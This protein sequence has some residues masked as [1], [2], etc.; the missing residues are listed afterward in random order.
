MIKAVVFDLDGTLLNT[1]GDIAKAHNV[2]LEKF[3]FPQRA[4]EDFN[5]IIG[6]GIM[7][8]IKKA[9]P[10]GTPDEILIKIHEGY[11]EYYPEHC[12]VLTC[13]YSGMPE[14][15]D[16]LKMRGIEIAVFTNKT[17]ITAIR[18]TNHFFPDAGF[19]FIWGNDGLRPL[20]P[21]PDAGAEIC[22]ALG[23]EPHEIAY[24][25]DSDTD[26][27]FANATG[28]LPVGACWGYRGREEL[29]SA[30][31]AILSDVPLNLTGQI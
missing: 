17:E 10:E 2:T 30:G 7:D 19:K 23:L 1:R 28:M 27:I 16:E 15:V 11:Q 14:V 29:E 18:I 5:S 13:H 9:A 22:K 26:M 4:E 8:A 25:G 12:T 24:V 6:G 31:A 21:A 3:G 20:K